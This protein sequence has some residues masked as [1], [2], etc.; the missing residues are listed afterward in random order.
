MKSLRFPVTHGWS[1]TGVPLWT[2]STAIIPAMINQRSQNF[3]AL[4]RRADK[5]SYSTSKRPKGTSGSARPLHAHQ[6]YRPIITARKPILGGQASYSTSATVSE[7]KIH[8]IFE[9]QT[10][11][12]QYI[13][14]DPS[15]GVAAII[16]PVLDY[17]PVTQAITTGSA[18]GLLSLA[19]EQG[20]KIDWILETHAHADHLT[21]ASYLQKR[22][23]E[24]QGYKPSIGIGKRIEQV[25]TLFGQRYGIVPEEYQCVFDKLFEDDETFKIG[26]LIAK[27]I[28]LPGH[29]P[30]H[31]G[32]HVGGMRHESHPIQLHLN[33]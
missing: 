20:Y 11:T 5:A 31:L 12:W 16:D 26:E 22:L 24:T 29:T 18:D 6:V 9:P 21:A 19:K 28:H 3:S 1:S 4:N 15:T 2:P 17:D 13:I 25:Q 7:P 33:N 32:Y 8:D 23:A 14:A 30:D 27:A 10:G